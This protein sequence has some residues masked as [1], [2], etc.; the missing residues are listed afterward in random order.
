MQPKKN[1]PQTIG[2][3]IS[4]GLFSSTLNENGQKLFFTLRKWLGALRKELGTDGAGDGACDGG[5][6]LIASGGF[7]DLIVSEKNPPFQSICPITSCFFPC[8]HDVASTGS[9]VFFFCIVLPFCSILRRSPEIGLEN[10][11]EKKILK[12]GQEGKY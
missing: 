5:V 11:A 3:S 2:V 10:R 8:C 12:I 7:S 6:K 1:C 4:G 9:T